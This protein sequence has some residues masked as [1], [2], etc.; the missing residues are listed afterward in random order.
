MDEQDRRAGAFVDIGEVET[1]M[2]EFLH[3]RTCILFSLSQGGTPSTD[4]PF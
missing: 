2:L 4:G 1:G 3:G